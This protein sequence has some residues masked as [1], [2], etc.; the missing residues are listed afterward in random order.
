MS[1]L[2]YP[3][4]VCVHFLPDPFSSFGYNVEPLSDR[5]VC[6]GRGRR[7]LTGPIWVHGKVPSSLNWK[8]FTQVLVTENEKKSVFSAIVKCLD[9]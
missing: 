8:R 9:I 4:L 3:F 7:G 2:T 1:S 6:S 5:S